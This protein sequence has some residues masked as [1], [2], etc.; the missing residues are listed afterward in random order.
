MRSAEI[1]GV[2]VDYADVKA[3]HALIRRTVAASERAVVLNVNVHCLNLAHGSPSLREFLNRAPM[4]FCDGAGVQLGLRLLGHGAPPRVPYNTWMWQLAPFAA[5]HG[6][7][8][9]LL[10][11]R[12]GVAQRAAQQ[13]QERCPGLQVAGVHDGYFDRTPGC[14]EEQAVIRQVNNSGAHIVVLSFGMPLQE[15]WLARVWPQLNANIAL[16]GGAALDY[17]AGEL[18]M[19]PRWL[20]DHGLEWCHR[21]VMEPRRLW[22]RYL[23]GNPLFLTRVLRE[24]WRQPHR[25]HGPTRG[26]HARS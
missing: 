19:P 13:L 25:D 16:T 14:P 15:Q 8:L 21:L 20:A 4:V 1:L 7:R 12:P 17:V 24:R 11:A 26:P 2:R 5:E 9:F 18:D 23:I 3:V 22:R 6:Y 10:G